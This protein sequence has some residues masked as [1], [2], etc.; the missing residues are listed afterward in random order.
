MFRDEV[1]LDKMA[2]V[3]EKPHTRNEL[4][5]LFDLEERSFYRYLDYLREDYRVIKEKRDDDGK[6]AYVILQ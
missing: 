3:L 1:K 5:T 4:K 2:K 6:Q